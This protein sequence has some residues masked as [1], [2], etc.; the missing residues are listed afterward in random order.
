MKKKFYQQP[1]IKV[2]EVPKDELLAAVSSG[3][4][5]SRTNWS[6]SGGEDAIDGNPDNGTSSSTPIIN[7]KRGNLWGD[8]E[9]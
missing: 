3:E 8:D 2:H 9:E 6:L 7:S 1:S 4:G 5:Y